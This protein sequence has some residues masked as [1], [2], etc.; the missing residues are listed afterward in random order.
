MT[1][2]VLLPCAF[3]SQRDCLICTVMSPVLWIVNTPPSDGNLKRFSNLLWTRPKFRNTIITCPNKI[4]ALRCQTSQDSTR[5]SS[6]TLLSC[7]KTGD[8]PS[9]RPA[10]PPLF[11]DQ[12]KARRAEKKTCLRQPPAYVGFWMTAHPPP[13]EGL[14]PSLY[15]VFRGDT[16]IVTGLYKSCD[17]KLYLLRHWNSQQKDFLSFLCISLLHMRHG[18]HKIRKNISTRGLHGLKTRGL[19]TNWCQEEIC[20]FFQL[21]YAVVGNLCSL[22]ILYA[23]STSQQ[24]V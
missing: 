10:P 5:V 1:H 15:F 6:N 18:S 4:V 23:R 16:R 22:F 8:Y 3:P 2:L 13:S 17:I 12:T 7:F 20:F 11:L 14:A 9:L 21:P 24:K 19:Y